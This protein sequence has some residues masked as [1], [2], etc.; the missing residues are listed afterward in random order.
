MRDEV[1]VKYS[2]TTALLSPTASKICAPRYDCTVLMPIFD[3]TFTTPLIAAFAKFLHAVLW[4]TPTSRP[5]L[6]MSSSVSNA[7]YGFTAPMP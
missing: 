2:S 1:H 6:I 5:S 3:A 7:R 4:S